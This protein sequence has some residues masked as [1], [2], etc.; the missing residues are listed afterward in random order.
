MKTYL[1]VTSGFLLLAVGTLVP[2]VA[3]AQWECPEVA[4]TEGSCGQSICPEDGVQAA[5]ALEALK[6]AVGS[7]YCASCRCDVDSNG[8]VT[9]SD[10]I[11]ILRS[12]VG[13]AGDLNCP[14]CNS[15]TLYA[16][17]G[18][19]NSDDPTSTAASPTIDGSALPPQWFN[20]SSTLLPDGRTAKIGRQQLDPLTTRLLLLDENGELVSNVVLFEGVYVDGRL[21]CSA[22]SDRCVATPRAFSQEER[23]FLATVFDVDAVDH[24]GTVILKG[25]VRE[26]EGD[27]EIS[28]GAGHNQIECD[29][30]GICVATWIL[31]RTTVEDE[32]Y[33]NTESL[34]Y[35]ARAFN[36]HTGEVGPELFLADSDPAE[37]R[38]PSVVTIDAGLFRV[39]LPTGE[40]FD[41]EVR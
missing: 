31:S 20:I 10:A 16:V 8:S 24:R 37:F 17:E 13:T 2:C 23:F 21:D 19:A 14:A 7:A 12:A 35:Y 18:E 11:R 30:R 26:G 9:A 33:S 28:T 41:F 39:T 6:A 32:Y 38:A 27:T 29:E 1:R 15:L 25:V 36:V 34:G 3:A 4:A 40:L 5:D 22:G